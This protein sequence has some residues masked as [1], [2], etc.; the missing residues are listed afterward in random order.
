MCTC[1]GML[2]GSRWLCDVTC[3]CMLALMSAGGGRLHCMVL[4]R[5]HDAMVQAQVM[6]QA[7]ADLGDSNGLVGQ[8]TMNDLCLCS[9]TLSDI[10]LM[11]SECGVDGKWRV[12]H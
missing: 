4:R 12:C 7:A 11:S 1:Y 5:G 10:K 8:G 6:F 9:R 2:R 3:R